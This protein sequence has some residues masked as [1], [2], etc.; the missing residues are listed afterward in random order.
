MFH[1]S[2]YMNVVDVL[3]GDYRM[4]PVFYTIVK[5]FLPTA[6][7][8]RTTP[9]RPE[10]NPSTSIAFV[11]IGTRAF[12]VPCLGWL[13]K[14]RPWNWHTNLAPSSTKQCY[15]YTI[16]EF[17]ILKH[18]RSKYWIFL[19]PAHSAISESLS[20][21]RTSLGTKRTLVNNTEA[22]LLDVDSLRIWGEKAYR[23]G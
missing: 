13:W 20:P 14:P 9:L 7:Q 23:I 6:T 22:A 1:I 12:A 5:P 10:S 18:I 19:C 17:P 8:W 3:V 11:R 2:E 4:K 21:I 16:V 15:A